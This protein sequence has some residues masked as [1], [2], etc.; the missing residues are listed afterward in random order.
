VT[1]E[2]DIGNAFDIYKGLPDEIKRSV[3]IFS[4]EYHALELK[5]IYRSMDVFVGT[6]LH[7]TIFALSEN[8]P[9]VCVTY[10]GTKALGVFKTLGLEEFVITDY[11][12][13][14]ICQ[15]IDRL[16]AER[17]SIKT[18]LTAVLAAKRDQLMDM[19]AQ[20]IPVTR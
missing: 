5:A 8:V 12:S 7:S 6:R 20:T 17:S 18:R 15:K 16:I 1:I 10:H 13:A 3:T 14:A 19:L 11:D 2:D 9:A 4:N